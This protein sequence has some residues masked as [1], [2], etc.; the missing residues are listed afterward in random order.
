MKSTLLSEPKAQKFIPC[1]SF[2]LPSKQRKGGFLNLFYKEIEGFEK[3][4]EKSEKSKTTSEDKDKII[5]EQKKEIKIL[6]E[7]N[8]YLENILKKQTPNIHVI[9]ENT[10]LQDLEVREGFVYKIN[11]MQRHLTLKSGRQHFKISFSNL[12]SLPLE[13]EICLIKTNHKKTQID[14]I[15]LESTPH[16][17]DYVIGIVVSKKNNTIKIK[18]PER[19]YWQIKAIHQKEKDEINRVHRNQN[20]LVVMVA[21]KII[22]IHHIKKSHHSIDEIKEEIIMHDIH[23]TQETLNIEDNDIEYARV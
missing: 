10:G 18:I 23:T 15:P 7:K 4:E 13:K 21:D 3:K 8:R 1:I 9:T 17:F 5:S 16:H 12:P 20:I 2:N 11:Y 14:L 6:E 19:G 22:R